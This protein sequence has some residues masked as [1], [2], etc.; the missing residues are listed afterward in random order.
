MPRYRH[1]IP[2]V[3]GPPRAAAGGSAGGAMKLSGRLSLIV[4]IG[5]TMVILVA[6]DQILPATSEYQAQIRVWLA[7]RAAG[8]ASLALVTL[9]VSLGIAMSHPQQSQWRQSK[10]IFPWHESLWVFT[11]AFIGVHVASLVVDN[12][13]GVGIAGALIPGLSTYR[14]VPVALGVLA[15]YALLITA[16]TAR[17]TKFLPAGTWLRLHRLSVVVLVLGW[18]HGVLAG[19][20]TDALRPAYWAM[21]IVVLAAAVY[22]YWVVRERTRRTIPLSP[23][24]TPKEERHVTPHPAP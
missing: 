23:A 12:Y 14:S 15:L 11:L 10:R 17:Y 18:A 2:F 3:F 5:L 9:T 21:A 1:E 6:T 8:L 22:R 20:D 7:A 24:L 4:L 13:S 19:T 16:L